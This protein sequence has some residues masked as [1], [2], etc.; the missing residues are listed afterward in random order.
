MLRDTYITQGED[1]QEDEEPAEGGAGGVGWPRSLTLSVAEAGEDIDYGFE[2]D[3]EEALD[4]A[5]LGQGRVLRSQRSVAAAAVGM[6][7]PAPRLSAIDIE[8]SRSVDYIPH[9]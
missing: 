2:D 9:R 8:L 3:E 6:D 7:A 1:F 4:E 5:G